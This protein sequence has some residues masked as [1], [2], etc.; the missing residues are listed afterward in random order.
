MTTILKKSPF[1]GEL[2]PLV[3][4]F[5]CAEAEPA[6]FWEEEIN[7]WIRMDPAAGDGAL[8]WMRKGT[9]VWLYANEVDEVVGYGSLCESR[10][11]DPAVVEK[12]LKIKRV[13]ISLIPA[14]GLDR[15]FQRGPDGT[16]REERYSMKILR[17]LIREACR[18]ANR[19]PFLGL[20]VHPHNE[21]AIRLY[22][23]EHFEDFSQKYR[24]E[25]A[26][27][28]YLSMILKLMGYPPTEEE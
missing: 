21:K 8:F 17:H 6:K 15:R 7:D 5:N 13:P 4:D 22:R 12:V 3:S 25:E 20:Y 1:D 26:G 16:E 18:H 28:E 11:P 14:V 10:W 19:Q 23:R 27:V 9:Q 24:H 2:L